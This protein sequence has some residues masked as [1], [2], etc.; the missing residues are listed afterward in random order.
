MLTVSHAQH[1][2]SCCAV[3]AYETI[4]STANEAQRDPTS[5][6]SSSESAGARLKNSES[7]VESVEE[8]AVTSYFVPVIGSRTRLSSE[9]WRLVRGIR[10]NDKSAY[11]NA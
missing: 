4:A 5:S 11:S 7:D 6:T 3:A 9:L 1:F 10:E 2:S 8:R